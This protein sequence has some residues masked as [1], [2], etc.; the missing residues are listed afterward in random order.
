LFV[1]LKKLVLLLSFVKH[2]EMKIFI[3]YHARVCFSDQTFVI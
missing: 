1:V 3:L 2:L